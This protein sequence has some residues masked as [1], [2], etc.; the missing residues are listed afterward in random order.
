MER[1]GFFRKLC[2]FFREPPAKYVEKHDPRASPL[3]GYEHFSNSKSNLPG[4]T[5]ITT[6]TEG[7]LCLMPYN[8]E[9]S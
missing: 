8:H 5:H 6:S 4:D 1:K 3:T 7:S 9:P 2:S